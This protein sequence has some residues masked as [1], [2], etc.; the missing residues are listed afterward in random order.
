MN[1]LMPVRQRGAALLV[2]LLLLL[3]LTILAVSAVNMTSL[4]LKSSAN[5]QD[6]QQA[7]SAVQQALDDVLSATPPTWIRSQKAQAVKVTPYST[8]D[9]QVYQVGFDRALCLGAITSTG[10]EERYD[11]SGLEINR[12]DNAWRLRAS[13]SST[14]SVG[15]EAVAITQGV[16]LKA[17]LSRCTA[18]E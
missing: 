17:E 18:S 16:V 15:G 10:Y 8:L 4:G 3:L 12:Y 9:K 14:G 5:Q 13:V 2:S 11:P 7:E 6:L 1:A